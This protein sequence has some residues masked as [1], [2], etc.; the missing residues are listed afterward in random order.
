MTPNIWG[1]V[2]MQLKYL[3]TC[4]YACQYAGL[5]GYL[6]KVMRFLSKIKVSLTSA[7]NVPFL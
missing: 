3:G 7:N 5:C 1:H 2:N 6:Q 4:Q